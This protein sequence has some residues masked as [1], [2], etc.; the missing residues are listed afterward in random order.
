METQFLLSDQVYAKAKIPPT[1]KVCLWL[2]VSCYCNS[3]N[4]FNKLSFNGEGQVVIAIVK[5]SLTKKVCLWLV[6]SFY[7]KS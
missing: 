7:S 4:F 3:E 5:H 1:N 6:V 2:G